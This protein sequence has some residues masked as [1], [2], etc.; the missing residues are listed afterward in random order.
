MT[1]SDELLSSTNAT[2]VVATGS[3]ADGPTPALLVVTVALGENP[4]RGE[5]PPSAGAGARVGM[6][7]RTILGTVRT[8][9]RVMG[10]GHIIDS[11]QE[12]EEVCFTL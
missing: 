5:N 9:C 11:G 7:A 6:T 4:P 2:P 3:S 8:S 1:P 10:T 12:G